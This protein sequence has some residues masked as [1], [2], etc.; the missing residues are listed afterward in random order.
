[1]QSIEARPAAP[2]LHVAVGVIE[3]QGQILI[4][5]R[6]E[7]LHQGGKWEFPGG[8]VEPGESVE[9]ALR[10]ELEEELGI[11][12]QDVRPLIRIPWHYPDRYVLLDVW[13]VRQFSGEPH[14]RE[15]QPMAWVNLSQLEALDFPAANRPIINALQLP[16]ALLITPE[17][18]DRKTFFSHLEGILTR[19]EVKLIQ[20]R[21]KTLAAPE[22]AAWAREV[23]ELAHRY[24]ARVM[25]NSPRSWDEGLQADGWHL[26]SAQLTSM[27][28]QAGYT[29]RLLSASC[30]N[31]DE[32]RQANR[33]GVDF[34]LLSPVTKTLSHP[35]TEPLG[36][37]R[38]EALA[39]QASM[40]VYALGGMSNK[41]LSEAR[42]HGAQGIAA[43]RSLWDRGVE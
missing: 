32:I 29:G 39:D 14:P 19:G 3:E 13:H 30:H 28:S 21:A 5:R 27:K 20:F 7:D 8:K 12:T 16:D 15:G 22:Y 4:T 18:E 41:D 6:A 35:D 43:I 31:L 40:P 33:V 1:M 34:I 11:T 9:E 38:F 24:G 42:H 17:P 26:T 23:S 36:W 2:P 10:R 37:S 25:L